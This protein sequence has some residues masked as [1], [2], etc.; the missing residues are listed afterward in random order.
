M[1]RTH[2]NDITQYRLTIPIVSIACESVVLTW[3]GKEELVSTLGSCFE[4]RCQSSRDVLE[5]VDL[6]T[7]QRWSVSPDSSH[8]W[9]S[10]CSH[11]WTA[12]WNWG[13]RKG[14]RRRGEKGRED[15]V[16]NKLPSLTWVTNRCIHGTPQLHT[17]VIT[18]RTAMLPST[19]ALHSISQTECLYNVQL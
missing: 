9:L 15:T 16:P 5:T 12:S 4:L 19:H 1:Y 11:T 10:P 7:G 2:G 8:Q 3:C 18:W 17:Q 14:G 13:G 6:W